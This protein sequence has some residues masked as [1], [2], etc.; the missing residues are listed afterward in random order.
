MKKQI[1]KWLQIL[2]GIQLTDRT[3]KLRKKKYQLEEQEN[4]LRASLKND[5]LILEETENLSFKNT[6][7][8]DQDI[9]NLQKSRYLPEIDAINSEI[10]QVGRVMITELEKSIEEDNGRLKKIHLSYEKV[11]EEYLQEKRGS[12]EG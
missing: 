12:E 3:D 4:D 2:R 1:R 11:T 7:Q 6:Q 8:R 5:H 9:E 10:E